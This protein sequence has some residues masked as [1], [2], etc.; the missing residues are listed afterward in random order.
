ME[1]VWERHKD[2]SALRSLAVGSLLAS[3][4]SIAKSLE[5]EVRDPVPGPVLLLSV[6]V[7]L[8][9]G[10]QSFTLPSY[11]IVK[12]YKGRRFTLFAS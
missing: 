10:N 4:G 3:R 1:E 5:C 6:C 12:N 2:Q 7:T 9:S 11:Q 8:S